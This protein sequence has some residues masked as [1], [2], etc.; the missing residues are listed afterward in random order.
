ML[1]SFERL[2]VGAF[3]FL[4]PR[5]ML[6]LHNGLVQAVLPESKNMCKRTIGVPQELGRS[7]RLLG[8]FP[9]GATGSPTPGPGRAL[10]RRGAKTTSA[11]RY[12]QAKATK[13]GGMGGRKSQCLDS[14]EES[15]ELAPQEPGGWEARHRVTT[16]LA[17][18]TW[19]ALNSRLWCHRN[20]SG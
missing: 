2:I 15:G 9:A 7:C 1:L 20:A 16:S 11:P 13:R 3:A 8:T 18:N 19:E 12:R 4:I 10:A 5:A 6:L 14:T 17:R